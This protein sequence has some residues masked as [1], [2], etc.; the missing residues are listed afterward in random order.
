[1]RIR[2]KQLLALA[3]MLLCSGLASAYLYRVTHVPW[4]SYREGLNFFSEHRFTEAIPALN[5][6]INHGIRRSDAF[7]S[8]ADSFMT[9][10]RFAEALDTYEALLRIDPE[11][12][13]AL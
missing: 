12:A 2:N 6:A 11:H 9:T 13:L 1:M 5:F 4:I 8:L 10:Q 3:M 7:M